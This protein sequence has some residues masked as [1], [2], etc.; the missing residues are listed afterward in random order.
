M[1]VKHLKC[2]KRTWQALGFIYYLHLDI[3][4][5]AKEQMKVTHLIT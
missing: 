4:F 1:I 5:D 3:F 2:L